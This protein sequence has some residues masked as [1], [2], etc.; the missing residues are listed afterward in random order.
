MLQIYNE[1]ISD[2]IDVKKDN[3]EV[4]ENNKLGI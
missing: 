2:L 3:L 1:K 4:R